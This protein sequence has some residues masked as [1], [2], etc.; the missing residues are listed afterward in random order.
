MTILASGL[1]EIVELRNEKFQFQVEFSV[2]RID[3]NGGD[4][5]DDGSDGS[6][7]GDGRI[8]LLS[9][10]SAAQWHV[11]ADVYLSTTYNGGREKRGKF[12]LRR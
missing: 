2:G 5:D 10:T 12:T 1:V 11:P 9:T 4:S 6:S 3:T 8:W 7:R